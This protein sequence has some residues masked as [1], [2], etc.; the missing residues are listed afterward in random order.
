MDICTQKVSRKSAFCSAVCSWARSSETG[1]TLFFVLTEAWQVITFLG[2]NPAERPQVFR[3]WG[4][5][6]SWGSLSITYPDPDVLNAAD[7]FLSSR[8]G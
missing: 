4:P 2:L 5:Q 7:H 3:A 1:K 8:A 6:A